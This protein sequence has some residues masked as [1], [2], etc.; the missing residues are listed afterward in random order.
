MNRK[1]YRKIIKRFGVKRKM[2]MKKMTKEMKKMKK[3][4]EKKQRKTKKNWEKL[5]FFAEEIK[6]N[7]KMQLTIPYFQFTT[8]KTKNLNFT[9]I[10][11]PYTMPLCSPIFFSFFFYCYFLTRDKKKN[12]FQF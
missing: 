8:L 4:K 3:K 1:K 2:K 5:F 12:L 11:I 6:E 10:S 9:V 7:K